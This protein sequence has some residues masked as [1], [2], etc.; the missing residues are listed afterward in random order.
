M[1][2]TAKEKK[3]GAEWDMLLKLQK[4]HGYFLGTTELVKKGH[5]PYVSTFSFKSPTVVSTKYMVTFS[6][7][8]DSALGEAMIKAKKEADKKKASKKRRK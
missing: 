7:P 3:Q 2:K 8:L 4:N 6:V 5:N 1:K